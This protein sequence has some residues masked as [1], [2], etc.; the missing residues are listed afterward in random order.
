MKDQI[1][2]IVTANNEFIKLEECV[3]SQKH[4]KQ[5]A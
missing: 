5:F 4:V 1:N 3:F 2:K